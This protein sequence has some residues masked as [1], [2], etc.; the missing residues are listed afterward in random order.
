MNP[1]LAIRSVH[2][3]SRHKAT[4]FDIRWLR[5]G[6][7]CRLLQPLRLWLGFIARFRL[8]LLRGYKSSDSPMPQPRVHWLRH[9]HKS[10]PV[11]VKTIDHKVVPVSWWLRTHVAQKENQR[12][13]RKAEGSTSGGLVFRVCRWRQRIRE[14]VLAIQRWWQEQKSQDH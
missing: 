12:W 9:H 11:P 14:L 7:V 2:L 4:G 3:R 13:K 1:I 10:S 6:H 5:S 8:R